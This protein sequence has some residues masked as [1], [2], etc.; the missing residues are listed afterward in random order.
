MHH[1]DCFVEDHI[2][3]YA[4]K[5]VDHYDWC[6]FDGLNILEF[7]DMVFILG[8]RCP[9]KLYWKKEK[10]NLIM[11][12]TRQLN[13]D[14]DVLSLVDNMPRDHYLNVYIVEESIKYGP[15]LEQND[16]ND[17]HGLGQND[18]NDEHGLGKNDLNDEHG[19]GQ[20][21][22]NDEPEIGE[23]PNVGHIDSVFVESDNDFDSV[24]VESV[25]F[26]YSSN[27][28]DSLFV[29]S[30]NDVGEE[31]T[32][33]ENATNEIEKEYSDLE[34]MRVKNLTH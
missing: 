24:F 29:E 17:E 26:D 33:T 7:V 34:I 30:D 3:R 20:N 9:V 1:G 12:S 32:C 13:T 5:F 25:N 11:E 22:M 31:E 4:R 6:R 16:L 14:Q 27:D 23:E 19:L 2:F 15:D 28:F 8:Y 10:D 21:D 18:L